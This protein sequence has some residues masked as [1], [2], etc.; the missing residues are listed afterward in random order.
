MDGG[1]AKAVIRIRYDFPGAPSGYT[2]GFIEVN[3]LDQTLGAGPV[4]FKVEDNGT[5]YSV[6]ANSTSISSPVD[7]KLNGRR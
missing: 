3:S 2:G 7:D 6:T 5:T 4:T 1:E